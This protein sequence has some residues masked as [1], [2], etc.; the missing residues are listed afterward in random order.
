MRPLGTLALIALIAAASAVLVTGPYAAA[1]TSRRVVFIS[2]DSG[3]DWIVDKL[4]AEA[5]RRPWRPSPA[6]A[7]RPRAWSR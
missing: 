6:T 1:G 4:I 5:R 3:A 2:F 7:R